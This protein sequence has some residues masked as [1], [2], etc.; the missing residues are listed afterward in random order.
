MLYMAIILH[1]SCTFHLPALCKKRK[2]T[3]L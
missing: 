1:C 2:R 3:L